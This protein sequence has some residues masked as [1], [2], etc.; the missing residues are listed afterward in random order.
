MKNIALIFGGVSAEHEVS[1]ITAKQVYNSINKNQ[2]KVFCVYID[3]DGTWW[4]IKDFK[5]SKLK[6]GNT[7]CY[8]RPNDNN[9]YLCK[10]FQSKI[11]IDCALLATHGGSG[12]NGILQGVL[13]NACV[14]YSSCGV[15]ASAITMDKSVMKDILIANDIP[16]PKYYLYDEEVQ[17]VNID[18]PVVVKPANLGSSIGIKV[19]HNKEELD[20]AIKIAK[21]FDKKILIEQAIFPLREVN[22]SVFE[23]NNVIYLSNTEQPINVDEVLSFEDKYL[24]QGKSKNK[25]DSKRIIP[26]PI[27]IQE[28][29][30]IKNIATKAYKIF[31]CKGIIRIDFLLDDN[32]VYLNELNTIPGSMAYY[33]WDESYAKLIDKLIKSCRVECRKFDYKTNIL[34]NYND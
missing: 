34:D 18:Y 17:N 9:L 8:F 14:P 16:T 20:E 4:Y 12:E 22:I 10:T 26:A 15:L 21:A 27:S 32:N 11:H 19:C 7:K 24:R 1:I 31:G 25:S 2:Y 33:L 3:T 28:E 13:E 29:K 23:Y 6:K 30:Q 5:I